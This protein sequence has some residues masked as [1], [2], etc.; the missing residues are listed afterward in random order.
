M[1][2]QNISFDPE[3][4]SHG[5]HYLAVISPTFAQLKEAF[6]DPC[7]F[8]GSPA[9]DGKVRCEWILEW[10][11]GSIST[12]YDWKMH[13]VSIESLTDWHIGGFDM[14]VVDHITRELAV[15]LVRMS[16]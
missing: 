4:K 7:M 11:D 15:A 8:V 14:K 12:I 16:S 9:D 10:D 3:G 2:F 5:S 6:G 1:E 13:H